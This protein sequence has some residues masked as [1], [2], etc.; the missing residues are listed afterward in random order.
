MLVHAPSE[1]SG[2]LIR[3]IKSLEGADYLN[4]V[5]SLTIE[6]PPDVDPELL[7]F[8]RKTN[9]PPKSS[10]KLT[11]RRR[12][13]TQRMTSEISSVRTVEAFYPRDPNV[14]HVLVL[15]PQTE[16]SPS[17]FHFLKFTVLNYKHSAPAVNVSSQ[18]L[19]M[20]LELPSSKPTD[21]QPFTSPSQSM[22]KSQSH[23]GEQSPFFL[24]QAPNSNAALYFGDK[25]AEFHSFLSRRLSAPDGSHDPSPHPKIMSKKF[26]AFMEYLLEFM[27]ARGYY[28]LYPSFPARTSFSLATVHNEL[29]HPPEEFLVDDSSNTQADKE[30]IEDP[31]EILSPDSDLELGSIERPLF[32]GSTVK[33]LLQQFPDHLP[34]IEALPL[35]SYNGE[36][37]SEQD[38]QRS[39]DQFARQFRTRIGGC[40]ESNPADDVSSWKMED[41][42]CIDH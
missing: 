40:Q 26:P 3:L 12:I 25:W 36:K 13:P 28:M 7:R 37:L 8:L 30:A 6:L 39:T 4:S 24:W 9:W 1:S 11:L 15:S 35:L 38:I 20:S 14:T 42:F 5:P 29:Y 22:D 33:S 2:S 31:A 23:N 34:E 18:L 27:R 21:D 17:F 32:H 19:G 16:L 10:G 41:L